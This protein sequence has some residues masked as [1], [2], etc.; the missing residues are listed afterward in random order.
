MLMKQD[1]NTLLVKREQ[2]R[3]NFQGISSIKYS[4][5]L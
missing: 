3:H 4:T 5:V 2:I 1:D